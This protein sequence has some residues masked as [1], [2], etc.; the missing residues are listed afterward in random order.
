MS[1]S[2]KSF[3]FPSLAFR[4]WQINNCLHGFFFFFYLDTR[5]PVR[6]VCLCSA[7]TAGLRKCPISQCHH[8]QQSVFQNVQHAISPIWATAPKDRTSSPRHEQR[9]AKHA[10]QSRSSSGP[11]VQSFPPTTKRHAS[12]E[13]GSTCE[14]HGPTY[15]YGQ[16]LHQPGIAHSFSGTSKPSAPS[17]DDSS[18]ATSA[19]A[20][21][22]PNGPYA[23]P[24]LSPSSLSGAWKCWG[25]AT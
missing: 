18:P 4:N 3:Q 8:D 23:T 14:F 10:T 1:C 13:H 9:S 20:K 19:A 21:R 25:H 12:G 7:A 5:Q 11:A 15:S 17:R 2:E 6:T 24:Q 22:R 16:P